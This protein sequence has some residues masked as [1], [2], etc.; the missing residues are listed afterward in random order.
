MARLNVNPTR[1]ELKRLKSRLATTRRGHKLLKDKSDE[2]VRI[3]S[4]KL[5]YNYAL[6]R[7]IERDIADTFGSFS[8]ALSSTDKASMELAFAMPSSSYTVELS[9]SSCMGVDIPEISIDSSES[10]YPYPYSLSAVTSEADYAVDKVSTLT[11]KMLKLAEIEKSVR[12]LAQEIEKNKRRVNAME[13]FMIPQ[14]EETIKYITL[15]LDENERSSRARL[16]KVK[17]KIN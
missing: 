9:S 11:E 1:M 3:F 6:R 5:R 15:K 10:D 14:L 12:M 4:Q 16:M 8:M 13:Y 2:M 7:E 17:D